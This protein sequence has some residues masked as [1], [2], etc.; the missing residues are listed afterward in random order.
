M[1]ESHRAGGEYT[2]RREHLL[3]AGEVEIAVGLRIDVHPGQQHLADAGDCQSHRQ[4]DTDRLPATEL[5]IEVLGALEQ[6]DEGNENTHEEDVHR[7]VALGVLEWPFGIENVGLITGWWIPVSL[8]P[9]W[10]RQPHSRSHCNS[11][12]GAR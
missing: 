2:Q 5:E 4:R 11:P 1:S 7:P 3:D 6:C 12:T 8:T 9:R 10:R